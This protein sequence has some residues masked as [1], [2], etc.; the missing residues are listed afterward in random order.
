MLSEV[1]ALNGLPI[2]HLQRRAWKSPI[3]LT[4]RVQPSSRLV[5]RLKLYRCQSKLLNKLKRTR[6][7]TTPPRLIHLSP[8]GKVDFLGARRRQFLQYHRSRGPRRARRL[9]AR[10]RTR[11]L[12][13]GHSSTATTR[14]LMKAFGTSLTRR[15][16]QGQATSVNAK[17]PQ[18]IGS[19]QLPPRMF[20]GPDHFTKLVPRLWNR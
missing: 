17:N 13:P 10:L 14:L 7:G 4:P 1:T 11:L 3:T 16:S 5:H 18:R 15:H 8:A 20:T 12:L 9:D 2:Q 19:P 6:E